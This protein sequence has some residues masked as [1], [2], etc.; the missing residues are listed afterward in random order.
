VITKIVLLIRL[1][2]RNLLGY[3]MRT[4][5][6]IL[7]V[8]FGVGSVIAMMAMTTGAERKL[9]ADIGRLG[10]DNIIINS[11]KP[12]EKKQDSGEEEGWTNRFG[13][14]YKDEARI[15]DTV[16]NITRVLPVHKKPKR[17]WYGSRRTR[18]TIYA[19]KPEHLDTFDLKV[20]RGRSLCAMDGD[21]LKRVCVIRAGLL[22]G[23]GAFL[24]PL[25]ASIQVGDEYYKVVGILPD[26]GLRGYAQEALDVDAKSTEIYVP[27]ATVK[28]RHGTLVIEQD[29]GSYK[30]EDVELSQ[31]VI[32][33]GEIDD[34][35]VT[36][37]MLQHV[38]EKNHEDKDY[39]MVV[40]L[41]V[42]EQRRNTQKVF[43]AALFAI[44]AI[45]LLVGG[46]GIANIMLATVTERTKEIGIR[47]ALGAKR[48]HIVAQFL[49]ETTAMSAI[50]GLM[51]VGMGFAMNKLL[52]W[53]AGWEGV[54]TGDSIV[55]AFSISVAV[56]I[57]SGILPARRAAL[58]DPIAALR[59]E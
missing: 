43:N 15:R 48:R 57:V 30:A 55:L 16:P 40:P 27:Y 19:V 7:G 29:Q 52:N 25:G 1:G 23:L 28:A 50:G 49:T 13:L 44:A 26:Q 20:I 22:K 46:I 6:T 21:R 36:A 45:S 56:G 9:L 51:G 10:I 41:E 38:L 53:Y 54:V 18:A 17:V 32:S 8:V 42:L 34:V 5:L 12:P 31:M 24:D 2:L 33:V 37:R 59:H 4:L 58:L 35:L 3:P 47:R 14:T 39:Q 11:V